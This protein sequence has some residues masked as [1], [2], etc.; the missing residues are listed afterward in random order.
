MSRRT[1]RVTPM[2]FERSEDANAAKESRSMGRLF[3]AAERR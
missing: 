1:G 2:A 3:E